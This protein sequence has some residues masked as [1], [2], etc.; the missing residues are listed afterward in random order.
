MGPYK[1][2]LRINNGKFSKTHQVNRYDKLKNA[3][4]QIKLKNKPELKDLIQEHAYANPGCT[5]KPAI[6]H[7]ET[8]VANDIN[9]FSLYSLPNYL[10]SLN[11]RRFIIRLSHRRFIIRNVHQQYLSAHFYCSSHQWRIPNS[12][13]LGIKAKNYP[14]Y[15][16]SMWTM[17]RE[18]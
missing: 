11:Y 6:E 13:S 2:D 4:C 3:R 1:H 7:V 17:L 12:E 14:R 16:Y 8:L 15:V 5:D 9:N 10:V 18:N